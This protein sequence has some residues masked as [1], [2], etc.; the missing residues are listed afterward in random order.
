MMSNRVVSSSAST[1]GA[2][3]FFEQ[4]VGAYWL[5]QLLV[6]GISPILHDCIVTEVNLQ[7]SHIGWKTDDFLII[8]ESGSGGQRKLAG[9]VKRTFTVSATDADCSKTV[10]AFWQDFHNADL[11]SSSSDRLALVTLRGTNTL[12]EHFSGLLD[13]SRAAHDS[14][15]FEHRLATT[16]FL[17]SKAVSYCDQLRL[18]I[19]E[20]E[21]K[22]VTVA[23][24][25]PF[26]RV[27]YILSLDLNSATG[28]TEAAIKTLLIHTN[29]EPNA[30]DVAQ[31]SWNALLALVGNGMPHAKCFR[32]EDLS[33][34]LRQ[35]HILLGGT[36]QRAL[37][38]LHEHSKPILRGIHSTIGGDLH[39]QRD[40]LV[41]Q[42]I[43]E[44]E[45]SQLV[46]ISGPAGCGKSNVAKDAVSI[47]SADYFAFSFRA[48]E[49]AQPHFDTTWHYLEI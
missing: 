49:F 33:Q 36:E 14:N 35:R 46:L 2:G 31:N 45:S 22:N 39:L 40:V 20:V 23:E 27:L 30:I 48:E 5:A 32:H 12:L 16:G 10:Q 17:S 34:A 18:I 42:V 13:C 25:W 3:T 21:G 15:D 28:Q 6:R 43:N 26:L 19:G 47:L 11:F 7:T 8:A 24:I 37:R 38:A 29:G 41:Q 4:H 1:G 44:L 9:Q